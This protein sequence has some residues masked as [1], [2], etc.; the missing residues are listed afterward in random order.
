MH[1]SM[2][3]I[4]ICT[5]YEGVRK[6]TP[7]IFSLWNYNYS[8][9]YLHRGYIPYNVQIIFP[10]SLLHCQLTFLRLGENSYAG[11]PKL[12]AEASELFIHVVLQLEVVRK[13]ASSCYTG[14]RIWQSKDPKSGL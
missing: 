9:I 13:R 1:T 4:K 14:S 11:R 6:V 8:E 12:I 10:E 5:L 2:N 3:P 7:L